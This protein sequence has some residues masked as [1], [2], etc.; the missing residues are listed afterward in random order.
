MLRRLR[1]PVAY[2]G[3]S[4]P[5]SDLGTL[6]R[7][8]K[9]P[10]VVFVAMSEKSAQQLINWPEFLPHPDGNG[11]PIVGY[12]GRI[13]NEEPAWREKIPGVYLGDSLREGVEKLDELL[14]RAVSPSI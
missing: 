6:V 14:R 3:Q 13:F 9:S 12:G 10:A 4:V 2:L 7:K 11:R 5:L 1:W 8:M